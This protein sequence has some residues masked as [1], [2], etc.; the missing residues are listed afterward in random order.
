MQQSR[1]AARD[2]LTAYSVKQGDETTARWKELGEFLVWKYLDGNVKDEF[3]RPHH[4]GYPEA[5][6][7][8][9]AKETGERLKVIKEE[10]KSE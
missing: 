3:G 1:E 7:R 10:K 9:V 6:L 5:W 2:Y 4:P 8:F